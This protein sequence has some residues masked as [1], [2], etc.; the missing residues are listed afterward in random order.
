MSVI[1]FKPGA[2]ELDYQNTSFNA[3]PRRPYI[4]STSASL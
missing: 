2:G 1:S 4:S 3:L